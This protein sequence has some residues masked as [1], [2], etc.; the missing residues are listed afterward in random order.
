MTCEHCAASVTKA[1]KKIDP[2]AVV[3]VDVA[4]ATVAVESAMDDKEVC[5]AIRSAGYEPVAD[6]IQG[7]Q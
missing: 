6:S 7:T 4:N 1:I 3:E 2:S 5:A